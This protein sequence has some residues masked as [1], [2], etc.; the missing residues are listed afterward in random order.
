MNKIVVY[1]ALYGNKDDLKDP[2]NFNSNLN[3]D[4]LCFTDNVNL[5]S[6]Y[7]KIIHIPP[8]FSDISKNSKL[9]KIIGFEGILNY[10]TA[11]WHDA[12][13]QIDFQNID[14]L[15]KYKNYTISAFRHPRRSCIYREAISCVIYSRDYNIRIVF[16]IFLLMLLGYPANIGL[17]ENTILVINVKKYFN[18]KLP[19]IWWFFV[20]NISKRDQL[21]LCYALFKTKVKVGILEGNGFDNIYSVHTIHLYDGFIDKS[22]LSK[23]NFKIFNKFSIYLIQ[24]FRKIAIVFN[25]RNNKYSI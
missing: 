16:Q 8:T 7:F 22:Y 6:E 9:F 2:I 20:K 15:L 13:L 4:L 24:V 3:I 17:T 18:S 23:I 1:T 25:N 19:S 12:S 10:E 5:K 21:S 14:Q 11:I